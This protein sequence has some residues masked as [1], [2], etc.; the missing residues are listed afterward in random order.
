MLPWKRRRLRFGLHCSA[1]LAVCLAA[2]ACGAG[3][4]DDADGGGGGGGSIPDPEG[5]ADGD[6]IPNGVEG[7]GDADDDGTP[8]HEDAD[9]DGDGLDDADEAGD[10]PSDPLDSDDDGTPD[11]LD[12]DSDDNGILDADEG[13]GD[14]DEDGRLDRLDE[15]DDDDTIPDEQE[16]VG[17]GADC[18]DNGVEDEHGSGQQPFDCDEDGNADYHDL[19]SDNDHVA[20]IDEGTADTDDD[21]FR[22][23]TDLDSDDDGIRDT[24]EAGDSDLDT[25]PIDTDEDETPDFQDADS[26]QDGVSDSDEVELGTD[27]TDVDSDDDGV[28]DLIEQVAATDPTDPDD[29][30]QA[31]GDF[32]FIVPY[33]EPTTPE[34]DT[35][36][37]RTNVQFADVYFA[38]D[39]SESMIA[40]LDAM[41]NT[42]SG[43]P[44]IVDS[45]TCGFYGGTCELDVDCDAGICFEGT[46]IE[47]PNQGAG[48]IPDL[49]TG[50]GKWTEL[51]TYHNILSLQANPITTAGAIPLTGPGADEAPYQ[52]SHCIANPLLCPSD[53]VMNC[54]ING[55]GCPNFRDEA[56]R[57]YVQIT[58][59]DQ[60]CDGNGCS[61]YTASSAGQALQAA[62]IKFMSLHGTND[63]GLDPSTPQSVARAI[64]IA[65]NTLDTAGQPFVY[66]AVDAAVVQK[67]TTGILEL[68]RGKS[69]FT[70]IAAVD[71]DND[72]IDATQFIDYFEVNVSGTG[73]CDVVSPTEDTILPADGRD[74]TFPTLLPGKHVCWDVHPVSVNT[75]VAATDEPQ[76]YPATLRVLGDG[77]TLDERVIYFLI[78]PENVIITPPPR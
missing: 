69:L 43:V 39:T 31:N 9:S 55:V 78:P 48:C 6:G 14:F 7:T 73:Q 21:S 17:A 35:V 1:I 67:A 65:S 30:P 76:I 56:I 33:Q 53:P 18:D 23:R 50:V 72:P 41:R 52:P 77:S 16:V 62:Q 22:D 75:T 74:D 3:S 59:A 46:C 44:A 27:P 57:I 40:E 11:F 25:P 47:D 26:D 45:L 34:D 2:T 13:D 60:Q 64:G 20:D 4:D 32:V 42:T 15:D 12:T 10:E 51:N 61:L 71:S 28:S 68:A 66:A 38:F 36:R 54:G 5:D 24:I 63:D 70:T 8:N 37:F 29:N 58:D 19:D 49:W